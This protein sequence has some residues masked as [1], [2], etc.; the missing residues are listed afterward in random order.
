MVFLKKKYVKPVP[1]RSYVCVCMLLVG[2]Y[3]YRAYYIMC[4]VYVQ[5]YTIYTRTRIR[6]R[7]NPITIC[8]DRKKK[9]SKK[10]NY[11]FRDV[12]KYLLAT[13]IDLYVAENVRRNFV[14]FTVET[15]FIFF[16]IY[17]F[18]P[19][20]T[21]PHPIPPTHRINGVRCNTNPVG[22]VTNPGFR[23]PS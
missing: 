2:G 5:V 11:V 23:R 20:Q 6:N 15:L 8:K 22:N 17:E 21:P 12:V 14:V 3:T 13:I 19:F 1:G 9:K 10:S 4:I 7:F 18:Y 16:F